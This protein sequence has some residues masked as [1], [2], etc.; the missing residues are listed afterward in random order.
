MKWIEADPLPAEC[1]NCQEEECYN[2]DYAGK[3]WYLPREE[4]LQIKRKGLMR[5]IARLQQQVKDIDNELLQIE[6][7]ICWRSGDMTRVAELLRK[8]PE[9]KKEHFK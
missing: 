3:R 6:L 9:Y 5:A 8:N 2:C 4:E 1:Q 7:D